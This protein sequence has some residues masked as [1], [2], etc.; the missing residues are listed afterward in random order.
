MSDKY[1]YKEFKKIVKDFISDIL[2]TFPE[3][4]SSLD[5]DLLNIF[6]NASLLYNITFSFS[7]VSN[8][9]FE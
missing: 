3:L 9:S 4:L 8:S 1:N 6:E 5:K 7:T 2:I